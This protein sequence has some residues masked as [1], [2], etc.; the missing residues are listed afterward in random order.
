MPSYLQG[1]LE[2][3]VG[4]NGVDLHA[5]AALALSLEGFIGREATTRFDRIKER[6][7][8]SQYA[9]EEEFKEALSAF[10]MVFHDDSTM[11]DESKPEFRNSLSNFKKVYAYW[12][13]SVGFIDAS[14]HKGA[15]WT[16]QGLV[17]VEKSGQII[18]TMGTQFHELNDMQCREL[19]KLLISR[20]EVPGRMRLTTFYNLSEFTDWYF[21]ETPGYLRSLGALDEYEPS[22]QR[23]ITTNYI[24]SMPN[25]IDS[26]SF[27]SVCC[28]NEC[29]DLM[30][31]LEKNFSAPLADSELLLQLVAALPSDTVTAPREIPKYLQDQLKQIARMNHG[32]VP[33]HGRLF[34]QW[35]HH[36][37]PR[38][39]PYP[40]TSGLA[41]PFTADEWMQQKGEATTFKSRE[42]V[43]E[44]VRSVCGVKGDCDSPDSPNGVVDNGLP[45][46]E[47]E[48]PFSEEELPP[49]LIVNHR[50]SSQASAS[51]KANNP[52][53][54][55]QSLAIFMVVLIVVV[56]LV[57]NRSG[58]IAFKILCGAAAVLLT[59]I[60]DPIFVVAT[61]G[62]G[63][64]VTKVLPYMQRESEPSQKWQEGKLVAEP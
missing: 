9:T 54:N 34:A 36:A 4:A 59:Y 45:F 33:L 5:I 2:Q 42:H 8:I 1:V 55:L 24:Q 60:A 43:K 22:I 39:C 16:D 56:H 19:K 30:A 32:K 28:R 18:Q 23:V 15:Q 35:M 27:F 49:L 20:E 53:L 3:H 25:C 52:S 7:D 62:A 57:M 13:D 40:H 31:H 50:D 63:L 6:L 58:N 64:V 21:V 47:E 26:S 14:F 12:N 61:L 11:L 29:E 17:D 48:S 37:Y 51:D 44:Y 41:H 38:E 46:S 10:L